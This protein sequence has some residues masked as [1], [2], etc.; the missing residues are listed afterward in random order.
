MWLLSQLGEGAG[1][2]R[3]NVQYPARPFT[4][5]GTTFGC[6]WGRTKAVGLTG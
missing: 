1:L 6:A 4:A 2:A 5:R 3:R